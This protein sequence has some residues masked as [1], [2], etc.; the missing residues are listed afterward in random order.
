M[1]TFKVFYEKNNRK[2]A[3]SRPASTA[4]AALRTRGSGSGRYIYA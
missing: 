1:F 2:S 4:G 3:A